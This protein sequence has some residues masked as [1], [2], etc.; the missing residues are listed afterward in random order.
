M[1]CDVLQNAVEA[2][3]CVMTSISRSYE[4]NWTALENEDDAFDVV[5]TSIGR[6]YEGVWTR[7]I[8]L[9]NGWPTG[10]TTSKILNHFNIKITS[11]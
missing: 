5:M 6:S 1:H 2:I 10:L 11:F 8:L 7:V 9:V 3:E 4:C